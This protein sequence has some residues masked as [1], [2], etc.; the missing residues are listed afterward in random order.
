MANRRRASRRRFLQC[1]GVASGVAIAGCSSSGSNN[2]S[3]ASQKDE[4]P[5]SDTPTESTTTNTQT[6]GTSSISFDGSWPAVQGTQR[7]T[8]SIEVTSHPSPPFTKA[9]GTGVNTASPGLMDTERIYLERD[10]VTRALDPATGEILWRRSNFA[11]TGIAG[12]HLVSTSPQHGIVEA[13]S[14]ERVRGPIG[15]GDYLGFTKYAWSAGWV[16]GF[17]NPGNGT[18]DVVRLHELVSGNIIWETP[19]PDNLPYKKIR[20]GQGYAQST[21]TVFALA[22]DQ[23]SSGVVMGLDV[24]SGTVKWTADR[25]D[26]EGNI[27]DVGP[28]VGDAV[29]LHS[30]S[31][32]VAGQGVSRI[33]AIAHDT[34]ERLWETKIDG[35]IAGTTIINDVIIKDSDETF[36]GYGLRSGEKLWQVT[37]DVGNSPRSFGRGGRLYVSGVHR[38]SGDFVTE[39]YDT[40]GELLWEMTGILTKRATSNALLGPLGNQDDFTQFGMLVEKK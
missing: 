31:S 37:A 32:N 24:E 4:T 21:E 2:P 30:R 38:S 27:S 20:P 6:A 29:L 23:D 7:W 39:V 8:N 11:P 5:R 14:G 17:D 9:W 33:R 10:A 1:L 26:S 16:Y 15:E 18:A 28:I 36:T 35:S 19:I 34:G 22:Y 3:T 40:N 13:T 12:D 25:T